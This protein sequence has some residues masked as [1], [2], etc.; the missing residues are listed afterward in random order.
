M[1]MMQNTYINVI[2]NYIEVWK[3]LLYGK[4]TSSKRWNTKINTNKRFY[5]FEMY[6]LHKIY[7]DSAEDLENKDDLY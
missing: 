3:I 1:N 7:F 6:D 4:E 2:Y 5:K